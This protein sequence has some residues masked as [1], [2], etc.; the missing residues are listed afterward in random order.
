M[1]IQ[2]TIAINFIYPK[3]A[4][5]EHVMRSKSN[6]EEFMIFNNANDIVDKLFKSLLARYQKNL[7]NINEKKIFYF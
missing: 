7:E 2:L 6:N 4:E 3:D 1:K 5:G